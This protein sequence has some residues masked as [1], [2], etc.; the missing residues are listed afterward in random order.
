MSSI[1]GKNSLSFRKTRTSSSDSSSPIIA[2]DIKF[3]HEAQAGET[4]IDIDNLVTPTSINTGIINPTG[5]QLSALNLKNNSNSI[6]IISSHKNALQQGSWSISNS[7]R[8]INLGFATQPNEVFTVQIRM[9]N[10][11][12]NVVDADAFAITGTLLA[13]QTDIALGQA[14]KLNANP[15]EQIGEIILT[16]D[17]VEQ[18]RNVNNATANPLADGNYEEV[19]SG[20][21][22]TNLLRLNEAY[23]VDVAYS[24]K[25]NGLIVNATPNNSFT[26]KLESIG[27]QL[28]AIIP[29]VADLAGV[30]ETN[31][32]GAPNS[33][34][35]KAFA[36]K[37]Y[38]NKADINELQTVTV[39]QVEDHENRITDVE[40]KTQ[41]LYDVR[42]ITTGNISINTTIGA[43]NLNNIEAGKIY[44]LTICV[45]YT[46]NSGATNAQ[47]DALLN[48]SQRVGYVRMF[49][50][51]TEIG[52]FSG[53]TIFEA[54][55]SGTIAFSTSGFGNGNTIL[56][57]IGFNDSYIMLEELPDHIET[58]K[59]S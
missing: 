53:T 56:G 12:T 1:H 23:P 58:N 34:D 57:G 35:L 41:T 15:T 9:S 52:T 36:D 40:G 49:A 24:V 14:F 3:A 42:F 6:I 28:D 54:S 17:G 5:A 10:A 18:L 45:V 51:G 37:V 43:W 27:G 2:Q 46:D 38:E 7:G 48:G 25:S 16:I 30:P 8:R 4:F 21:N 31:F 32:Q 50:A 59:W 39:P 29:T 47:V 20:N 33:V 26:Q 55:A 22:Q 13:G 44:K 11:T 19:D